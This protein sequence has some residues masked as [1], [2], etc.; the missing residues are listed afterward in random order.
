MVLHVV[1]T[2][3][4]NMPKVNYSDWYIWCEYVKRGATDVSSS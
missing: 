2:S 4:M 3:I 1:D